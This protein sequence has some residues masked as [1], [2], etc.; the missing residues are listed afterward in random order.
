MSNT[1]QFN[2]WRPC[3]KRR[4]PIQGEFF[5]VEAIKA[6]GK[7]LVRE[8]TQNSLD[9][10]YEDETVRVHI[11]LS[12][13]VPAP[14]IQPFFRGF[15]VHMRAPRS[16]LRD[17]P[18]PDEDCRF[19]VFEDFGTK[20]LMGDPSAYRVPEDQENHFY[21]F[22]RAEGRSNKRERSR[23]R[24]GVGKQVFPRASRVNVVFG[25]TIPADER[26]S[27]LMGMAVLK[28]H[29]I[30]G[31]EYAP[32]GWFGNVAA[33]EG[34]GMVLP[35]EDE[36][37]IAAFAETFGVLRKNEPGLSLVVPYCDP[38][39]SESNLV[40][41]VLSGYFWPILRGALEVWVQT[42]SVQTI[43]SANTLEEE[44]AKLSPEVKDEMVPLIQLAEWA[45]GCGEASFVRTRQDD[46]PR[47]WDWAADRFEAEHLAAAQQVF[48]NGKRVG[49]RVP[50]AI[51][52]KGD[53]PAD[54][55]FDLFLEREGSDTNRVPVYI[56]DGIIIPDV[57]QRGGR[58]WSALR[59]V[60]SLVVAED[61]AVS[62]FLGDAENPA[63]TEWQDNGDNFKDKYTQGKQA[64]GF[65]ITSA[66]EVARL[67]GEQDDEP[68]TEILADVFY[69]VEV[70]RT[71][72]TV[73]PV[74]PPLPPIPPPRP[75][76]F[77]IA[78]T[79]S[80]FVVR[81]NS[82]TDGAQAGKLLI[83]AAY[84]TRRRDA[85]AAYHPSDFHF[86]RGMDLE[87]EGAHVEEVGGNSL[88]VKIDN[89][90]FRIAV[91][92]FDVRRDVRVQVRCVEDER[93]NPNN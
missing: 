30:D 47:G 76:P 41:A 22:F 85:F 28:S 4:D 42:D 26:R 74:P 17:I 93:G 6:P 88:L 86:G 37:V 56:R 24:W 82:A 23:G 91:T 3:D 12:G 59:G 61:K 84:A 70:E 29:Q 80:G 51:T 57:R 71:V 54:T 36:D 73:E 87:L 7:A 60:R 43:L 34:A 79:D 55:H 18:A 66:V 25:L 81:D 21:N 1:W 83:T 53:A 77:V 33:D 68:D 5:A 20:G 16:G 10:R 90:D 45:Q 13:G 44:L 27:R 32:D 9:A 2:T 31:V 92:G 14:V 40:E 62:A 15:E 78:P 52:P 63:H 89:E 39:L 69:D 72:D 65:I 75:Q 49:I 35:I 50:I 58:G 64:L 11:R 19:L 46:A 48:R 38:E 8:G 67:L